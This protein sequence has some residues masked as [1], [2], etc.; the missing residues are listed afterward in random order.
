MES[1]GEKTSKKFSFRKRRSSKGKKD[2]EVQQ[3]V[4][5]DTEQNETNLLE[6]TPERASVVVEQETQT[7]QPDGDK[8]AESSGEDPSPKSA[9][10]HAVVE[11]KKSKRKSL[12]KRNGKKSSVDESSEL[13][14]KEDENLPY[15]SEATGGK[16]EIVDSSVDD[17]ISS[18]GE[19][20]VVCQGERKAAEITAE[21]S[22]GEGYFSVGD[23]SE[24][25]G[26]ILLGGGSESSPESGK[27][28][29]YKG[30][31]RKK[32]FKRGLS[33]KRRK[34]KKQT[35]EPVQES[36]TAEQTSKD[37]TQTKSI[38]KKSESAIEDQELDTIGVVTAE[39]GERDENAIDETQT[40]SENTSE[41]A[42]KKDS[43]KTTRKVSFVV[44]DGAK[45]ESSDEGDSL[46]EQAPENDD[47]S[48]GDTV[49]GEDGPSEVSEEVSENVVH[50][51]VVMTGDAECPEPFTEGEKFR[52]ILFVLKV[53]PD[54]HLLIQCYYRG[55][56]KLN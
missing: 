33:L 46:T 2:D 41:V 29:A 34:S 25:E 37:E 52:I 13:K 22:D 11:K 49:T 7:P 38:I 54:H 35:S 53:K 21:Q 5:L 27:T 48:D 28:E 30:T 47:E 45:L 44:P 56:P 40:D 43:G 12:F 14:V 36:V 3:P 23:I 6:G 55:K 17:K 26:E 31:K 9:G 20:Q 18:V 8:A 16:D 10:E 50:E 24:T 15:K 51:V 19:G 4:D 42:A 32:F 1:K 39:N